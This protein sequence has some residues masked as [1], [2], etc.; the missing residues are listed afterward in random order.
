MDNLNG[1]PYMC[2]TVIPNKDKP[3][4]NVVDNDKLRR[5]AIIQSKVEIY[6]DDNKDN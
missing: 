5:L 1:R 4:C 3:L 6:N 2:N